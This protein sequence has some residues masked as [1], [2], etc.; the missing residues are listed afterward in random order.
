M[1]RSKVVARLEEQEILS[2]KVSG[3]G[4]GASTEL[5]II[6]EVKARRT[7]SEASKKRRTILLKLMG[8]IQIQ[9]KIRWWVGRL[10]LSL[11]VL[12]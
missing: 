6:D 8:S 11:Q 4:R 10:C 3:K 12:A 2:K 9:L 5:T 7:Q 1:P